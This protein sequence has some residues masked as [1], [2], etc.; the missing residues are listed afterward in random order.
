MAG[1]LEWTQRPLWRSVRLERVPPRIEQFWRSIRDCGL[2]CVR[3]AGAIPK[4]PPVGRKPQGL[5]SDVNH[6]NSLCHKNCPATENDLAAR[7]RCIAER[8][9][10]SRLR[11]YSN[12]CNANYR[13]TRTTFPDYPVVSPFKEH[14]L[15]RNSETRTF[16]SSPQLFELCVLYCM[17]QFSTCFGGG[18]SRTLTLAPVKSRRIT[19]CSFPVRNSWDGCCIRHQMDY[20]IR[21]APPGSHGAS[22]DCR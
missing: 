11:I 21:A 8:E 12:S 15:T 4:V 9:K 16:F 1:E 22:I 20:F 6:E 3:T 7:W 10:C 5:L 19:S 2:A 17:F 14:R 18:R 13:I